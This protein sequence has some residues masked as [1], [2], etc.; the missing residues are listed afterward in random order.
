MLDEGGMAERITISKEFKEKIIQPIL[1][2]SLYNLY[3]GLLLL[4]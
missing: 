4:V 3:L 1:K 2:V